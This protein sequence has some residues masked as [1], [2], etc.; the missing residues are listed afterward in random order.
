M[1]SWEGRLDIA[2]RIKVRFPKLP[3][4]HIG[5]QDDAGSREMLERNSVKFRHPA[6]RDTRTGIFP[7]REL[8]IKNLP[9]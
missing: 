5:P 9:G 6:P 2:M 3:R 8:H 1:T 4:L 7:N